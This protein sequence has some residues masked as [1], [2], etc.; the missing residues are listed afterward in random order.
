[1]KA[2]RPPGHRDEGSTLPLV[3]LCFL[4]AFLLV[5]GVTAASSAFLAQR[6]LQADCD[7]AA[8]AAASAVDPAA[9][10]G[11]GT[12]TADALPLATDLAQAAV[13][14]FAG[15]AGGPPF[16][17]VAAVDAERVQVA[18]GRVVDV[19][20]GRL[21]GVGGGLERSTVSSA[22]SPLRP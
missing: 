6:D 9:V 11:G 16:S 1:M 3:L 14:E 4:V 8:V 18:C 20:F 2:R 10:Y 21:F 5:A 22:R 19:P 12:S 17:A 7:A 13:E 15:R